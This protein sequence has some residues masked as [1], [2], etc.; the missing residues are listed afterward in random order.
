MSA[1][2]VQTIAPAQKGFGP[3]KSTCS[4]FAFCFLIT[5]YFSPIC[6]AGTIDPQ[7]QLAEL[8]PSASFSPDPRTMLTG[9]L[10]NHR[11]IMSYRHRVESAENNLRQ[12]IG[13]YL[14]SVDFT[15]DA[16]HEEIQ[17]ESATTTREWRHEVK[18][19]GTQLIT[20]FGK[21][22]G[23]IS[24]NRV[25]L[26]QA[27]ATLESITQQT[28]RDGITAYLQVVRARERLKSALR[29]EGRI[30]ELTGVEK[31]L[32]EKGAGLTSDVLQ[33]KSQLAGAMALRVEAK[34]ELQL[35]RNHFQAVF[36]HYPTDEEVATFLE[37]PL[38]SADLPEE[39]ISAI[40]TALEHNP[41]IRITQLDLDL[42]KRDI[43]MARSAFFPTLNLF[44]EA[45]NANDDSGAQGYRKDYSVGVEF[46]YNLFNGA[47]DYAA[48]KSAA[49]THTA[50]AS[51]L[52]HAKEL[53]RE[54]VRNSWEQFLTL[55]QRKDLL[56]QQT[57]ILGNFL[58]LAKKER[59]MGT[60]SLLDVLTG[61]VNY[62]N[63]QGTAIAAG[64]DLKI[65]A[66]NLLF[67][68]G[69]MKLDLIGAG[70]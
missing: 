32:V 1:A 28:L 42:S 9:L 16:G 66:F 22:T 2:V 20:D 26:E 14:P 50:A 48:V 24:R 43:T 63:A 40:D 60:R 56:D 62:I 39:L 36:Y 69:R 54:Q 3:M 18:L 12:S 33:A 58:E 10:Q 55:S 67:S 35:A 59:T 11:E 29:S 5:I 37:I 49:A 23:A 27:Q 45:I 46:N 68:M 15:G 19:R 6:V 53:I 64:E 17:K 13:E 30:K 7:V 44:G 41:E 70:Q 61:E 21:T 38:P 31:A 65:A 47:G 25:A 4:A 57:G 8:P 51:H 52:A 34:G